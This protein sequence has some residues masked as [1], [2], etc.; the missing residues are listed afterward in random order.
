MCY[1]KFSSDH[2]PLSVVIDIQ[3][4]SAAVVVK[5]TCKVARVICDSL[6]AADI[7]TYKASTCCKQVFLSAVIR[8]IVLTLNAKMPPTV[9]QFRNFMKTSAMP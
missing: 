2:F 8:L 5:D 7:D 6:S 1:D 3:L 9:E 4:Q